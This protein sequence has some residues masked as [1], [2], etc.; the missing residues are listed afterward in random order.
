VRQGKSV[1]ARCQFGGGG[2]QRSYAA[3]VQLAR[4]C[5]SEGASAGWQGSDNDGGGQLGI[6]RLWPDVGGAPWVKALATVTPVGAIFPVVGV[7]FPAMSSTGENPVHFLDEQRWCYWC[8]TLRE[9]VAI[10]ISLGHDVSF[11]GCPSL[12][13]A[14]LT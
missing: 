13:S 3:A 10:G 14:R 8:C 11:G 12:L 5:P 6:Q 9:G 4:R 7:I 2:G 1:S